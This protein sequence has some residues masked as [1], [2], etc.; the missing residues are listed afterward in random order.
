M[1]QCKKDVT[2]LLTHWSTSF[3][4][5]VIHI[6]SV[7]CGSPPPPP[8]PVISFN[9]M[10]SIWQCIIFFNSIIGQ[11]TE[12]IALYC[13]ATYREYHIATVKFVIHNHF[14]HFH[15]LYWLLK[16][17]WRCPVTLRCSLDISRILC[18][19]SMASSDYYLNMVGM[20]K[21]ETLKM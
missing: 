6:R 20:D 19:S 5:Q 4:L 21:Y 17:S 11:S 2:P 10:K 1:G 7:T 14:H 16:S 18:Y 13:T 3:L 9:A 12:H 15:Y 8:P